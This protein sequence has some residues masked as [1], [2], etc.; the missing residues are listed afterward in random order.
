MYCKRLGY[1]LMLMS[2]A[3]ISD[4][5]RHAAAEKK[6]ENGAT[7]VQF[8]KPVIRTIDCTVQSP[9][10]VNAYEQTSIFSKVSGFIKE[11]HVDIGDEVHRGDVLAEIFV[12]ELN[13]QNEQMMKQVEL[14]K[15]LVVVAK[16]SIESAE[17]ELAEAKANLGKYE[18]DIVRW[19]SEVDRLARMVQDKVV[20]KDILT[21]TRAAAR[22]QRRDENRG[23]RHDPSA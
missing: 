5:C 13:E 7:A 1:A 4:G 21:E 15:Q 22:F 9:G 8:I 12:P 14:D 10:F 3:V 23:G 6:P 11:S 17:A 19:Q 18:A 2:L 16:R 20:D